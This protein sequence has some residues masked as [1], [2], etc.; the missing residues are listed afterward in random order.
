M[1]I[2]MTVLC[3]YS[4]CAEGGSNLNLIILCSI[5]RLEVNSRDACTQCY[6]SIHQ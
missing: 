3:T 2:R 4:L 1:T 5:C 6:N